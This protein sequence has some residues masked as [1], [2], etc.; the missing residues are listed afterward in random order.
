M[1]KRYNIL[2][3]DDEYEKELE[4]VEDELN[5]EGF[6]IIPFS[7]SRDG[8]DYLENNLSN[9]DAAILDA[10]VYEESSDERAG[11]A[12]LTRSILELKGLEKAKVI[13]FVIYTG[14]PDLLSDDEFANR[15]KQ[16]KIISKLEPKEQLFSTLHELIA[17]APDAEV[18]NQYRAA[19]EACGD[20]RIDPKFWK[21]LLPV[22]RTVNHSEKL[23][24]DP[25]NEIR[26]ALEWVFRYLHENS[27]IHD[28]LV[29]SEDRVNVQ[30]TSHFLAGNPG[31]ISSDG[32]FVQTTQPILPALLADSVK[33][34]IQTTHPG[35]HT[36]AETNTDMGKASIEAVSKHC[37]SHHLLQLVAIMT[38]DLAVW[39]VNYVGEHSDAE[40]N[41][42][43][44]VEFS[45]GSARNGDTIECEGFVIS[46][47]KWGNYFVDT[48]AIPETRERNVRI[49]KRLIDDGEPL[50]IG[51]RVST[52][53][54][55]RK[56]LEASEYQ[57]L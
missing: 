24:T 32:V 42:S 7:N 26:K 19:Y 4:G 54:A 20:D 33:F 5:L 11:E 43:H 10:K 1:S 28:K 56:F 25:F 17:D 40:A 38:A 45:A 21:H 31:K 2:W 6:D 13:P 29:D 51:D 46:N 15:W 18:R 14:Q 47:D 34:I 39:A 35:S 41:R 37:P 44:W 55:D 57:K 9:V 50:S 22:L 36:E 49:H 30:S 12:G 53:S 23:E 52:V 48:Q 16:F 27:I 3:I 8:I